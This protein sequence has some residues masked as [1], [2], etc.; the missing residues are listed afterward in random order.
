MVEVTEKTWGEL[1]VIREM[2]AGTVGK[3]S[4]TH[5]EVVQLLLGYYRR[6]DPAEKRDVGNI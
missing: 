6:R 3:T 5:D 2:L 4:V 1:N